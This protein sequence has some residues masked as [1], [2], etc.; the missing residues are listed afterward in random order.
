MPFPSIFSTLPWP[1][2]DTLV[3]VVG[4]I[5]SILLVYAVLLEEEKR[6][7]A[8]LMIGSAALL[9]YAI[10]INSPIF[11]F[12]ATGIFLVSGREFL[13]I[14]RKKHFHNTELVEEYKHPDHK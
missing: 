3:R 11:I 12:L 8:V 5:G 2:L 6:Q 14:V 1:F 13:Q 7:D 9:P 10:F 4:F